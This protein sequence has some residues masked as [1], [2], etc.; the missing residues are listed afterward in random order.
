MADDLQRLEE[1][2]GRIMAG[3]SPAERRRAATK[4]GVALR[5]S[6]LA[7][8]AANR[9][10][11]GSAMEPRKPRRERKKKK[12]LRNKRMFLRMRL[13]RNWRIDATEDGVEIRPLTPL[14]ETIGAVSQFGEVAPVGQGRDG[15]TIRVRYAERRLL[16]FSEEDKQLAID[17]AADMLDPDR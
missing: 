11:D 1:W 7:R 9:Q 5:K 10:E 8:I 2:F 13:T 15:R 4:L 6:N 17:I 3:L 16:G 14:I 12:R